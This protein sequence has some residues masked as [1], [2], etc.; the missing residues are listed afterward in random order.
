M[1]GEGTTELPQSRRPDGSL[2]PAV[3]V[4]KGYVPPEEQQT[5]DRF[6]DTTPAGTVFGAETVDA[7]EAKGK[8]RSRGKKKKPEGE[9]R[10]SDVAASPNV[11]A[12]DTI[13][14]NGW[15]WNPWYTTSA[16]STNVYKF[17][18]TAGD[19][20]ALFVPGT[21][22]ETASDKMC[23]VITGVDAAGAATNKPAMSFLCTV[24]KDSG[25]AG[26]YSPPTGAITGCSVPVGRTPDDP[27]I[28]RAHV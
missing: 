2:R 10:G 24:H 5:Y 18:L 22:L 15:Q 11:P 20:P 16:Y 26:L 4:R 28:G 9:L 3:R 1:P 27:K 12:Y 7:G 8:S 6:K 14:T 19:D 25:G 21:L 13:V 23:T 17:E